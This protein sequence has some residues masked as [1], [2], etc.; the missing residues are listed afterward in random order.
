[1]TE[2]TDSAELLDA[3]TMLRRAASLLSSLEIQ[4][5]LLGGSK[6]Q[7]YPIFQDDDLVEVA[8]PFATLDQFQMDLATRH[9]PTDPLL[10]RMMVDLLPSLDDGSIVD[11]GAYTG[12]LG[13]F[14]H[15]FLKP[16]ETHLIEPQ[17]V[18]AQALTD[19]VER[20]GGRDAGLFFH[21]CVIG[22]R[23]QAMSIA[24]VRPQRLSETRFLRQEGGDRTAVALD[25]LALGTVR[26]ILMDH[27][28]VKIDILKGGEETIRRD[29]P[30]ICI[31]Q[32]NRDLPEVNGFLADLGYTSTPVGKRH[33][34]FIANG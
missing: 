33:L 7:F 15:K 34:C 2:P 17:R 1:M 22:E 6:T 30:A 14:A 18:C 11:I 31:D 25:D 28:G 5:K 16:K 8:L 27:A 32:T 12:T 29:N 3:Q 13:L 9:V 10:L 26:L 19:T 4:V 23:G 21:D 20:A 24:S